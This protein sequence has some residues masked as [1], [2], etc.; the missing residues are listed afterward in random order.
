MAKKDELIELTGAVVDVLP[1]STFKVNIPLFGLGYAN[2]FKMLTL[3]SLQ[4]S[5]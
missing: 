5:V 2:A 3:F 4:A 1:N